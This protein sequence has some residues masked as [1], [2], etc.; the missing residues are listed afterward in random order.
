MWK[1]RVKTYGAAVVAVGV[2]CV[3]RF[4]LDPFFPAGVPFITFFFAVMVAAWYGGLGPALVAAVLSTLAADYFFIVPIGQF[5]VT[6]TYAV[7]L[8]IFAFE[9]AGIALLS[10]QMHEAKR[11]AVAETHNREQLL[12]SISDAFVALDDQWRYIVVNPRAAEILGQPKEELLGRGMWEVFPD[13]VGT[14]LWRESHEARRSKQRR[15]LEFFSEPRQRWY[16]KR[17]Y[18]SEEG[19]SIFFTDITEQKQAREALRAGEARYRE[20]IQALPAA[21][22]TCDQK[23]RITLCNQ[24][25]A[26]LWGREPEVGK[27]LWCGSWKIYRPDGTPLPLDECPMAVTLREGR[28]VR[29]EEIIIERPDGV[30]RHVLPHPEPMWNA[31]GAVIGAVN[32][33]IDITELKK[34]EQ[35]IANLAAIVTSSDDAIIG[36]DL[37]GIVT[38]WNR[39]A[40]RLFGYTAEDM[41]G[42]PVTRL[43][44]LD[45]QD[46]EPSILQR[47]A[48]G[49]PIDHYETIRRRKDG[50]LL[51]V[52]LTV[53]PVVDSQG[54]IIG[55]SK[56]ARDITEQKRAEEALRERDR[57]LTEAN[58]ALSR[59]TAALAEANKELESFSYSVSHDLRAPLRTID[60][61][62][63][64]VL[65]DHA[66]R[67]DA[68]ALRCLNIVRKAA[69]QAGELIDDLLEL[70]RL[71]RQSMHIQSVK[72]ADLVHE[73][74]SDLRIMQEG[75]TIDLIIGELPPCRGDRRLLKLAWSNLL[76]NAFKYTQYRPEARVEVGWVPDDTRPD[77]A[78][79]YVKDNGVGFD[80]KYVEKL[81]GVFQRLHRKE[82]FEGT[83]VGL[84]IVQR[85]VHRHGG[86]VWAEGKVDGGAT[87]SMSLRKG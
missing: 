10:G 84:A 69:G 33:L 72:M 6:Q 45:R 47:L 65:E 19:L 82:D 31:A 44:P 7:V 11:R 71:G 85:I 12:N 16:E 53:S 28:A 68:E 22:Y 15:S 9:A 30:R 41:I 78:V 4:L 26:A 58:E 86:R 1:H 56:I 37:R 24:A 63:R 5:K 40:E 66:A 70:S 23:G 60:A 62:S 61:F 81:F 13:M 42:Q 25:A 73:A 75:R 79:Y 87:F 3:A 17:L 52:S 67:L 83:G 77:A 64:I 43:I 39:A 76:A 14:E 57:A 21:V 35:A 34:A 59:Q 32:M 51:N 29:G 18:P 36:K 27:D 46:E 8:G 74:A 2:A 50:T 48:R 38:S 55:A 54:R 20:L 80:M 49:E